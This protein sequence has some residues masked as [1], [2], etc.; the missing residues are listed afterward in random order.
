MKTPLAPCMRRSMPRLRIAAVGLF[1]LLNISVSQAETRSLTAQVNGM[2][3]AFCNSAIEKKVRAFEATREVYVNLSKR[4]VIVELKDGKT[5]AEA[6]LDAAIVE[7]G[8]AVKSIQ[9]SDKS[10]AERKAEL[11]LKK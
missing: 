1:A 11:G 5:L 8:F 4:V 10:L 7:A 9:A 2:V 3:C 6:Q